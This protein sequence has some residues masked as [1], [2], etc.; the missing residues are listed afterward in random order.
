MSE[1]TTV[2]KVFKNTPAGKRS[3]GKPIKRWLE[4]VANDL[5]EMGFRDWRKMAK[6]RDAWKLVLKGDL[7]PAWTVEP[8]GRESLHAHET[9]CEQRKNVFL[10][11]ADS[12]ITETNLF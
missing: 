11:K 3:V 10:K 6:N 9:D 12:Y 8:V 1:E 4:D 7:G 5:R 2:K